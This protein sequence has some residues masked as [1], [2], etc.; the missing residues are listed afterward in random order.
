[1]RSKYFRTCAN[2]EDVC[3]YSIFSRERP[4]SISQMLLG[5]LTLF[6][7]IGKRGNVQNLNNNNCVKRREAFNRK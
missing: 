1:M 5:L 7:I 2:A 6:E 3:L 4:D